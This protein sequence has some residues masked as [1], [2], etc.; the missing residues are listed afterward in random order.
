M[1]I[2]GPSLPRDDSKRGPH[3]FGEKIAGEWL[4]YNKMEPTQRYSPYG[5]RLCQHDNDAC[6]TL[7]FIG[8]QLKCLRAVLVVQC[9]VE[10]GVTANSSRFTC[11]RTC[12]YL[13][14]V[15]FKNSRCTPRGGTIA[16]E[17]RRKG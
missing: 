3:C 4:L 10:P 13:E 16:Q 17:E 14:S 15:R 8:G 5:V 11:S 6:R 1:T 7:G 2:T 9:Q 12:G